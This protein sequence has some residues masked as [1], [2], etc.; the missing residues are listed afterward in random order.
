MI[1]FLA[2]PWQKTARG[3][4]DEPAGPASRRV[5]RDGVDYWLPALEAWR[6][7]AMA[8]PATQTQTSAAVISMKRAVDMI[9][10]QKRRAGSGA[11]TS[12]GG[13]P[14]PER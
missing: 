14:V 6:R 9:T 2:T 7:W 13:P 8:V 3:P 12:T 5:R 11:S 4:E 1:P 10:P